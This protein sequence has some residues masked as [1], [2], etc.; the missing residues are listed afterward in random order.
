MSVL[1]KVLAAVMQSLEKVE[2]EVG[3]VGGRQVGSAGEVR[4]FWEGLVA[5][6]DWET[7]LGVKSGVATQ[8]LLWAM[9]RVA[10]RG[11]RFE[12]CILTKE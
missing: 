11:A 12:M 4:S 5:V 7:A 1:K 2:M 8:V 3:G 6:G 10:M 9:R